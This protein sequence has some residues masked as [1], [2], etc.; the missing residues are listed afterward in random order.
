MR[1]CIS[2]LFVI[3]F[4]L[5]CSVESLA[6][7]CPKETPPGTEAPLPD[8][9]K[10]DAV[11]SGK[12]ADI[13]TVSSKW[14]SITIKVE[15]SWK[16]EISDEMTIFTR[17][18]SCDYVFTKGESYLI[19]ANAHPSGKGFVTNVCLGNKKLI[20]ANRDLEALGIGKLRGK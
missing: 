6:C 3:A 20:D 16:G 2:L 5:L 11:V 13:R 1:T 9:N 18:T 10:V 15:Q 17:R 19:Y 8:I 12:V 14:L 7:L 4:T